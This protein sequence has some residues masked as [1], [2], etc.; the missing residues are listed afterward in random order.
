MRSIT[1]DIWD[2]LR[3]RISVPQREILGRTLQFTITDR[4]VPVNLTGSTVTIYAVKPDASVVFNALTV[5]TPTSGI[6]QITLT[7]Q[8]IVAAG[9]LACTLLI[10]DSSAN[11]TR[12]QPFDIEIIA[13]PDV[14]ASV[15]STS[16]YNAFSTAM[17]VLAN[18][19]IDAK[20][21][22]AVGDGTTDDTTA[23]QAAITAAVAANLELYIPAGTYLVSDTLLVPTTARIRGSGNT[24]TIIHMAVAKPI[25]KLNG[26][27][28]TPVYYWEISDLSLNGR[29]TLPS[30]AA[31][32]TVGLESVYAR[33]GALN[34]VSIDGCVDGITLV[35]SFS[36][37]FN[38]C[39][40]TACSTSLMNLGDQSN[41]I[42]IHG[43]NFNDSLG[44]GVFISDDSQCVSIANSSFQQNAKD[45]ILA[46]AGYAVNI[47]DCYFE[48]NNTSQTAGCAV[49]NLTGSA[50]VMLDVIISG[51][52]FYTKYEVAAIKCDKVTYVVVDGGIVKHLADY[53]TANTIVT[54]ANTYYVKTTGLFFTL[55]H[56]DVGVA[57]SETVGII[58][59]G[60]DANGT[61]I[62][63]SDG[64]LECYATLDLGS[65]AVTA[66]AGSMFI[67]SADKVWTFPHVFHA[68][69]VPTGNV[70]GTN[71]IGYL[72]TVAVSVSAWNYRPVNPT[73]QTQ[74]LTAYVKAIG[75]W[76]A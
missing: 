25:I 51:C 7:E 46:N 41:D 75:R 43:C 35:N 42:L 40:M 13:S 32:A 29:L 19:A 10:V 63:Y 67:T 66:G 37:S 45:A 21:Q 57:I 27:V 4:A 33:Q 69:P 26:T 61:Y 59:T 38:F 17:A 24:D 6:A 36:N 56:S 44:Y 15:E 74:S 48:N 34:R 39:R 47:K 71:M 12:T 58:A 73:S 76:K 50:H 60:T 14:T 2:K 8:M 23:L 49:I 55:A 18:I 1:I 68:A 20:K 28:G 9:T 11:E 65:T 54:T 30:G 62:K 22:G 31:T 72:A 70:S 5:I 64:A 16:E 53:T 52:I 3:E